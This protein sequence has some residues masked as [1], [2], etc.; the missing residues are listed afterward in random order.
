M[1]S[2]LDNNPE[3]RP[4]SGERGHEDGHAVAGYVVTDPGPAMRSQEPAT[5]AEVAITPPE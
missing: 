3:W 1:S 5:V 4:R 2:G